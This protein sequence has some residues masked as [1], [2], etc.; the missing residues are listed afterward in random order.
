MKGR[1]PMKTHFKRIWFCIL[2][3]AGMACWLAGA[4][5]VRAG[6][7]IQLK[8]PSVETWTAGYVTNGLRPPEEYSAK[9]L[10]I[11]CHPTGTNILAGQSMTVRCTVTNTT[12]GVKRIQAYPS[13]NLH[14]H[15]ISDKA[16]WSNGVSPRVS[17]QIRPPVR[18][19]QGGVI[20][21]PHT[22]L[23]LLLTLKHERPGRVRYILVYDP[24]IHDGGFF[25]SDALEQ[26]KRACGYSNP[27]EYEVTANP[28]RVALTADQ[29]G[30]LAQQ[31]ANEKAQALYNCQPFRDAPPAQWVQGRWQWYRLQAQGQGDME[32]AVEFSAN[33]TGP[34]VTVVRLES[35]SSLLVPERR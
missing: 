25:G 21:P 12:D 23:E 30:L 11:E 8:P 34:K 2:T 29:A 3:K 17:P 10:E 15:C 16:S 19:G 9:G 14:F 5:G 20:L 35:R 26:A 7:L 24:D 31:L 18:A 4:G 27:F 28:S 1:M 13:A 6:D 32:A 33:G 22:S